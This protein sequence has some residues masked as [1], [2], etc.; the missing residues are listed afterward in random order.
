MDMVKGLLFHSVQIYSIAGQ[1]LLP[2][3]PVTHAA[4][5][6]GWVFHRV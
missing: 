1:L 3:K 2:L 6:K 4:E 5:A